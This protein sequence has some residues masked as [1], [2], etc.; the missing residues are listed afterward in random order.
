[1]EFSLFTHEPEWGFRACA[2]KYYS[3]FP[4]SFAVRVKRHGGW[5][6]WGD[7]K[8]VPNIEELCYAYHWGLSGAGAV[9]WDNEHGLD[10]LPYI[11]ATNMH[12]TMEGFASATSQDVVK[13]LQWIADP[14]RKDPLPAWKYDH[15]YNP[16]LGDRDAAIGKRATGGR[17]LRAEFGRRFAGLVGIACMRINAIDVDRGPRASRR[18]SSASDPLGLIGREQR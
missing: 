15:P 10:A 2:A 16:A 7:C 4:R 3:M 9:K 14:A 11:E 12:Q 1:V 18:R 17:P 8:D 13:R 5:V 6:C